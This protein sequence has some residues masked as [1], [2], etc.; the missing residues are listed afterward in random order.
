[1]KHLHVYGSIFIDELSFKRFKPSVKESNPISYQVG[2]NV[3]NWPI[4]NIQLRMEYTA[5]NIIVYKHSIKRIDWTS[6]SYNMGHFMGDNAQSLFVSGVYAPIRGLQFKLDYTMGIKYV[7]YDYV[8]RSILTII[9]EKPFT[10]ATWR[11]DELEFKALYEVVNNAYAV[12]NV[13]YGNI[14]GISVDTEPIT[15]E[16]RRTAQESLD[17]YTPKFYQGEQWSVMCGFS[18]KFRTK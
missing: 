12:V 1:M 18:F 14:R 7:D 16:V 4:S 11:M 9:S 13:R 3:T 6:N 10:N 5:T 15:G 2:F 8:R 17:Y